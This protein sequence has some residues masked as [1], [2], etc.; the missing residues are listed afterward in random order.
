MTEQSFLSLCE[1][2]CDKAYAEKTWE[3]GNCLPKEHR[4]EFF[5][6]VDLLSKWKSGSL[7]HEI[8]GFVNDKGAMESKLS[9]VAKARRD[10]FIEFVAE[11][12][13]E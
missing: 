5:R 12:F 8:A 9:S 7:F 3:Q 4:Q 2:W 11:R 6:K 10:D 13:E 1:P